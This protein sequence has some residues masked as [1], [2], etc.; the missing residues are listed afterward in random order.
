MFTKIASTLGSLKMSSRA[1][2]T[3]S[4]FAVPPTSRKFAGS[5]PVRLHNIHRRHSKPCTIDHTANIAVQLDVGKIRKTPQF[6]LRVLL[7]RR[8]GV[9]LYRAYVGALN[10]QNLLSRR[11]MTTRPSLSNTS[12]FTST[13]EASFLRNNRAKAVKNF[14]GLSNS[15]A[16]SDRLP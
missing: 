12:G 8:L 3:R 7:R 14:R 15:P 5:A 1:C 16:L 10:R 4:D 6:V 9:L 13:I 2:F 11:Q